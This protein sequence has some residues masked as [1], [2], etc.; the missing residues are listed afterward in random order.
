MKKGRVVCNWYSCQFSFLAGLF[1]LLAGL[2]LLLAVLIFSFGSS[3]A[4]SLVYELNWNNCLHL[5]N[6][7][8]NLDV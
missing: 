4:I 8:T 6:S 2:V 1:L 5:V 7:V 3:H